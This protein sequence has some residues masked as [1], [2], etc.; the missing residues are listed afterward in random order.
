L[1]ILTGQGPK[2]KKSEP[3]KLAAGGILCE[4][5]RMCGKRRGVN[6]VNGSVRN[7]AAVVTDAPL[8]DGVTPRRVADAIKRFR[9]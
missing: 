5:N 4:L 7:G 3:T 2:T 6:K 1:S 9:D 8:G